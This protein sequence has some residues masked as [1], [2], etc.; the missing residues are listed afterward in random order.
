MFDMFSMFES[1]E[2]R[3]KRIE[4]ARKRIEERLEDVQDWDPQMPWSTELN[5]RAET[6]N[7]KSLFKVRPSKKSHQKLAKSCAVIS[8][9]GKWM[10]T[11]RLFPRASKLATFHGRNQG[12]VVFDGEVRIPAL[13]SKDRTGEWWGENPW[14]SH[15]P[16]EVFTLRCGTRFAKGRVV[17]C[18]L[19]MG[20]QLE[21]VAAR[22][23]VKEI[24]LVE[25]DKGLVDWVLPQLDLNGH[26]PEIVI[27]DA[28]KLVPEMTADAALVDIYRRYGGNE[29]PHC[30]N[31]R[32][33]WVWGSQYC[34]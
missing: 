23:K 25:I 21:Q 6:Y 17:V 30:P 18:G 32:K 31:I 34:G 16:M 29:F 4:C 22:K 24:V 9:N 5:L 3:Q 10:Y 19:G 7:P 26:E 27:G 15:T 8:P 28:K 13:F 14:M 2:S 20:Y 33:V 11:E 1:P 12:T